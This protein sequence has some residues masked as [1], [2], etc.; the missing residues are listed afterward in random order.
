[1]QIMGTLPALTGVKFIDRLRNR[2]HGIVYEHAEYEHKYQ[3]RVSFFGLI[4]QLIDSINLKTL[5]I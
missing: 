5:L 3:I 2:T 4:S 1:M